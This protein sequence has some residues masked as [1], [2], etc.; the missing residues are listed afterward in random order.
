MRPGGTPGF[1]RPVRRM[2]P[3]LGSSLFSVEK[4]SGFPVRMVGF[5]IPTG[6]QLSA[7]GCEGKGQS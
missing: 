7:P 4:Q 2:A 6:L 5:P 3:E 1:R